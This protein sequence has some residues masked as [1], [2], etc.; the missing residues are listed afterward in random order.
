TF[1]P[2]SQGNTRLHTEKKW[3]SSHVCN[4]SIVH[5]QRFD[6]AGRS[7]FFEARSRYWKVLY[8]NIFPSG[9]SHE[10]QRAN[11][12]PDEKGHQSYYTILVCRGHQREV[13]FLS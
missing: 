12:K 6:A 2:S 10:K 13:I 11:K 4:G 1:P 9:E 7:N 8:K 5:D 3:P